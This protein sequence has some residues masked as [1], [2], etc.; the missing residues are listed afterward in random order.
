MVTALAACVGGSL[1]ST[2]TRPSSAAPPEAFTC[3]REQL[4]SVGFAQTAYDAD[5]LWLTA[6]RFNEKDRRAD[7]QFRRMV[8]RLEI[9]V[10]PATGES[11]STVT[12]KAS[13]FAEYTTQRGPTEVQERAS[14]TA[15]AAAQ[16][17]LRNCGQVADT[18]AAS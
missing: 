10:A 9:E 16:T 13:T 1:T 14:E 18:A 5:R 8:D 4:K 6:R 11:I 15:S 12:V 3:V 2:L 17:I 7:T